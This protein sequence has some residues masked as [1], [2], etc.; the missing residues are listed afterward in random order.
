MSTTPKK[1]RAY[2]GNLRPRPNLAHSLYNNLFIPHCLPVKNF[3]DNE[4]VGIM[5]AQPKMSTNR[6]NSLTKQP[7]SVYALVE[8]NDVDYAIQVLDGVMFDGRTLRVSKEKT[9]FGSSRGGS[10]GSSRWAGNDGGGGGGGGFRG[11]RQEKQKDPK[12]AARAVDD[13]NNSASNDVK[14]NVITN[15]NNGQNNK[16][17]SDWSAGEEEEAVVKRV[18][19][20]IPSEI[21]ESSDEV[22]AA[23][24][25]TA[26]M[27]LLSSVDAFGLGEQEEEPAA[28]AD[29]VPT[30][31]Q[32]EPSN[33]T[34]L[35][36]QDFQS[37]CKLPL[38]EL[39]AEYGEQDEDWKKQQKLQQP[40]D[41]AKTEK[42]VTNDDFQSRCNMPISDL[43]AEYGEE[44]VDWKKDQKPSSANGNHQKNN[45]KPNP[46]HREHRNNSN[47]KND[48]NNNGMLAH[49]DK[50][51]IHLELVSF[52]YKY[53]APSHSKRGFTYAH[54]LSPLDVR[55]LDRAPGHVAKFNGL[56]YLVK[57][58]LLNPSKVNADDQ[59]DEKEDEDNGS[60]G[61][62][63]MRQRAN[64]IADEIIKL[65][66]ESIDE[67]GHGAISPL[68]MT[69]SIGSEYGRHRA[70]VLVE[71][72][73]VILRARL[74]RNDGRCFNDAGDEAGG[75][76]GD[77][78]KNG[79]V[80]QPVSV[81]TRHRD[82][83]ARHQDEEAFGEDLKR[84][85]FK[86]EKARRR[87]QR[88]DES[89]WGDG[90]W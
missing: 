78:G 8:F 9:N 35:T 74:R 51:C 7:S 37:R 58:A 39:L 48:D 55:D 66:V 75:G 22:G 40:Q 61:Q 20:V 86:A 53:G 80:R 83:E 29:N 73:A 17:Q 79:V 72:L 45:A 32:I 57:R 10:F 25:C 52:G 3:P 16:L 12:E 5:V 90:A 77:P 13:N 76:G 71:H 34:N 44:D 62:S 1:R 11:K 21:K 4:G 89:G 56:S 65:L 38:S 46:V 54:P 41:M 49:F 70:V 82:V 23:L 84:E 19:A 47:T 42:V 28:A 87:Q 64:E 81:G 67:G 60:K 88:M 31:N 24:A 33:N 27:T 6:N 63:P 15:T 2:V 43:L 36:N 14:H 85:A 50:A 69:I 30:A 68:T 18:E 59:C 26:A